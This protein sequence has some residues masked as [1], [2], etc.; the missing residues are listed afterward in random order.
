MYYYNKKKKRKLGTLYEKLA[1]QLEESNTSESLYK[2]IEDTKKQINILEV[3]RK[4]RDDRETYVQLVNSRLKEECNKEL[5]VIDRKI[6]ELRKNPQ[7]K[8]FFGF[9]SLKED[10]VKRI[11]ELSSKRNRILEKS[12]D[13]VI[14]EMS[15]DYNDKQV[16]YDL[17][18]AAKKAKDKLKEVKRKE[19]EKRLKTKIAGHEGKTRQLANTVKKNLPKWEICP[20][21]NNPLGC[22]SHADHIYPVSRNGLSTEDNMVIVCADCNLKKGNKTLREFI[23]AYN[24]DRDE[25]E[26]RLESLGKRF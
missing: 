26:K 21:C 12:K 1:V 10:T 15:W 22:N 7:N 24:L 19:E 5:R 4:Q 11:K 6:G 14:N 20:Y 13:T 8:T 25:I 18:K 16:L 3:K 9:G 23:L 2:F 17:K